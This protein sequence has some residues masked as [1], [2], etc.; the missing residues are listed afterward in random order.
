MPEITLTEIR[1][2]AARLAVAHQ[3]AI[4]ATASLQTEVSAAIAPLFKKHKSSIDAAAEEEAAASKALQA[5]LDGSPQLFQRP[6]SI[7]VDGVRAGYRKADDMLDWDDEANVI[8]RIRALDELKPLAMVLVRTVESLNIAALGELTAAQRRAIGV[9]R[10]DGVDQSFI[11]FGDTDVDRL[12]KALLADA[13]KRQG[14]DE[15]PKKKGKAKV[16]EAA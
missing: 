13:A 15:A 10:I 6:R 7:S 1:E 16:K 4:V 11:S 5:L 14:E 12:T 3:A 9:R 8:T 2:A